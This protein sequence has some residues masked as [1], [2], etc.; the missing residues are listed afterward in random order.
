MANFILSAFA[1]EAADDLDGQIAALLE[2]GIYQIEPRSINKK[3]VLKHTEEELAE[4]SAKLTENGIGVYS[5]GVPSY[6]L[7]SSAE[8]FHPELLL[9]LLFLAYA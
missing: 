4:I 6:A 8:D 2:N 7:R 5:L 3:G 9:S 1:D